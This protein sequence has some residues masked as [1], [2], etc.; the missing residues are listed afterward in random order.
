[1][2]PLK[3]HMLQHKGKWDWRRDSSSI[4]KNVADKQK[5]AYNKVGATIEF[6]LV[7][8]CVVTSGIPVD[9][10]SGKEPTEE[11]DLIGIAL[12]SFDAALVAHWIASSSTLKCLK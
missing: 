8:L 1:M 6:V 5:F 3:F 4:C 10:L 2:L 9:K 11:V 7:S 12:E